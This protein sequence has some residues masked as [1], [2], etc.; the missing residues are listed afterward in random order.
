[1]STSE[2]V[3][4]LRDN[5]VLTLQQILNFYFDKGYHISGGITIDDNYYLA[6]VVKP[7]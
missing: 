5:D 4:I 3:K 2:N 7:F 6:V 1:M